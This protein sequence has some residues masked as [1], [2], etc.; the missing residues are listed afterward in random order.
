MSG[1]IGALSGLLTGGTFF[2]SRYVFDSIIP[3]YIGIAAGV[4]ST[5]YGF[6]MWKRIGRDKEK[7][8]FHSDYIFGTGFVTFG[9]GCIIPV[10]ILPLLISI[11]IPSYKYGIAPVA[12]SL[13]ENIKHQHDL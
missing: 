11:L 1:G 4:M 3:I 6:H 13:V 10:T 5:L 9:A 12:H 8:I 7:Q 2:T